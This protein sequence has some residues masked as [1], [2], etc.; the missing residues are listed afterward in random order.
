MLVLVWLDSIAVISKYFTNLLIR[1]TAQDPV[2]CIP[3]CL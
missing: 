2:E 1:A 3:I